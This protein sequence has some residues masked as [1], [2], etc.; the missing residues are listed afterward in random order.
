[1]QDTS[2]R[3]IAQEDSQNLILRTLQRAK[4]NWRWFA[5]GGVATLAVIFFSSGMAGFGLYSLLS[6]GAVSQALGKWAWSFIAASAVI[7]LLTLLALGVLKGG[8]YWFNHRE[9]VRA[10]VQWIPGRAHRNDSEI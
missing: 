4:H 1:M 9:P 6:H 8:H 2:R 5:V 7:P 10:R 3:T